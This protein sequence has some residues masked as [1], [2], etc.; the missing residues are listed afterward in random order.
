LGWRVAPDS[1]AEVET[2][3]TKLKTCVI[4]SL[5]AGEVSLTS[6]RAWASDMEVFNKGL[7]EAGEKWLVDG[8]MG[9]D[10]LLKYK[11]VID[12]KSNRLYLRDPHGL[13]RSDKG[14]AR[15]SD[16]ANDPQ[17]AGVERILQGAGYKFEK[18]DQV[19][20]LSLVRVTIKGSTF[21]FLVDTGATDTW[22]DRKR[23]KSLRLAWSQQGDG[24][25]DDRF[26]LVLYRSITCEL[27]AMQIAGVELP[28]CRAGAIELDR[29]N[30]AIERADLGKR[31][32]G[33]LDG[34]TLSKQKAI[35]DY[36]SGRLYLK[37]V[38]Q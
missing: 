7:Q 8:T 19:L 28:P 16:P 15:P 4:P 22:I 14:V 31:V 25:R 29:L 21:R 11:A 9:S 20:G 32:N 30:G 34:K 3:R 17:R 13:E 27:P 35:V 6:V 33:V 18:T 23:T 37:D 2:D 36:A 12:L 38:L 10:T 24:G 1:R 5:G 26:T